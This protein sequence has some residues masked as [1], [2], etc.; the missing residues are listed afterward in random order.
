MPVINIPK[1]PD[2]PSWI[3]NPDNPNNHSTMLGKSTMM[4]HLLFQQGHVSERE[5]RRFEKESVEIGKASSHFAWV[6]DQDAG[7]RVRGDPN[8]PNNPNNPG[9]PDN[10]SNSHEDVICFIMDTLLCD[11]VRSNERGCY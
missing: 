4:G 11:Y 6:L 10:L 5:M 7:E 8:N 9:H 3:D 1:N 2:N